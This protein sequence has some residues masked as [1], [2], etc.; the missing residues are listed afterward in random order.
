MTASPPVRDYTRIAIA[1]VVTGLVISAAILSAPLFRSA[2]TSTT[3]EVETSILTITSPVTDTVTV[4]PTCVSETSVSYSGAYAQSSTTNCTY[5][6]TLDV[7]ANSSIPE[8]QNESISISVI[9]DLPAP[10]GVSY[11]TADVQ[12]PGLNFSNSQ[13][14]DYVL[15]LQDI[16]CGPPYATFMALYNS[17]GTPMELNIQQTPPVIC[18]QPLIFPDYDNFNAS[19]AQTVNVSIGGYWTSPNSSLLW[20]G[21]VYHQFTPGSYTII[22]VDSWNQVVELTFTVYAA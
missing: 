20:L 17:S 16:S 9:N 3:T 19:Q 8:G 1:L 22:A 13:T 5:W 18:Y 15:P 12:L 14:E 11:P 4:P 10:R 21:A 2:D 7:N 6:L